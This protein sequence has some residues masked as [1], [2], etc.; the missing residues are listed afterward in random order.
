MKEYKI[1]IPGKPIPWKRPGNCKG[2]KGR[3]DMQKAEKLQYGLLMKEVVKDKGDYKGP[4][5]LRALFYFSCPETLKKQA[6]K[7]KKDIRLFHT[8]KPD[9]DNLLKFLKDAANGVLWYDDCQVVY[10]EIGKA[11][12]D[13][14]WTEIEISYL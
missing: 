9:T 4:V 3:Y 6:V 13:E 10:E 7:L 14:P 2:G 8:T 1:I 12:A 11:Y 5:A